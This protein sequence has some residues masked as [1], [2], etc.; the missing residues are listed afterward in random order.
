LSSADVSAAVS[1]DDAEGLTKKRRKQ[2]DDMLLSRRGEYED[3]DESAAIDASLAALSDRL[4]GFV[5]DACR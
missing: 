2:A 5:T 4:D 1:G 3:E